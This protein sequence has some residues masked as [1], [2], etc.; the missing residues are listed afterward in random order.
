MTGNR[1]YLT[2]FVVSAVGVA[3]VAAL[4][5]NIFQRKQEGRDRFF[6]VVPIARFETDPQ[7]W[8]HNF[9]E[10][11]DGWKH[12]TDNY[13]RTRYGGSEQRDRLAENPNLK[14]LYAGY[15]FSEDYKEE[16]GH[17]WALV[18]VLATKRLGKKKPGTCMS[19]KSS[20]NVKLWSEIGPEKFYTTSMVELA[21][22]TKHPISCLNCHDPKTMELRPANPAFLSAM[23]ERGV[24]LSKATRQE[25]RSYVC[26]QCHVEYYFESKAKPVLRFPWKNGFRVDDIE[27]YYEALEFKD[28]EHK[29]SGAKMIKAQ[30]PEFELWNTGIHARSGVSCAD[31]HMP[32]KRIGSQKISDHWVRS[33]LVNIAAACETCHRWDEKEMKDRV[34]TIQDRTKKLLSQSETA[35]L[36]AVDAIKAAKSAGASDSALQEARHLHRRAQFRWDF[37]NSENSMGFHSPQESARLLAESIDFARQ[38]QVAALK[39]FMKS[40]GKV[41]KR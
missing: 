40:E 20:A 39:F 23:K 8:G 19:C 15:P 25:M 17:G 9:P 24:D 5:L 27:A 7:V 16:R 28:W 3:L 14:R 35:I 12:T 31:C 4:L 34:L 41:A 18:D 6:N 13:G 29:E 30:H 38:S 26:G 32:F 2:L 36:A 11:Y 22:T 1:I 33:P 37:M 21:K 10:Q